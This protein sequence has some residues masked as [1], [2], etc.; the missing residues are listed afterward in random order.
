MPLLCISRCLQK[1]Q[2]LDSSRKIEISKSSLTEAMSV[3]S[4]KVS[5]KREVEQDEGQVKGCSKF[6]KGCNEAGTR[7]LYSEMNS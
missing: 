1:Y 2:R 3:T 6:L 4:E 7:D 5:I